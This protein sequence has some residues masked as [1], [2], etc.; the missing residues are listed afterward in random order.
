MNDSIDDP[1]AIRSAD[2][3][4]VARALDA[5]RARTLD[6]FAATRA[7]LGSKLEL[8]YAAEVNPPL[9]ELGHVGWFEEFWIG[10]NCERLR[11]QAARL[12]APRAA[13][14][15]AGA[16]ALYDSSRVAHARRWHLDLPDAARTL[17]QLAQIRERTQRL[18]RNSAPDDDALYF[19]RLVLMH[20]AMHAEAAAMIA[21][22]LAFDVRAALPAASPAAS[23]HAGELFLP[24][25]RV[26]VG[27]HE[28]GFAF[29]NELGAHAIELPPFTI[30][31]APVTWGAYLPFIEAGGYDNAKAWTRDG[32]ACR[33]TCRAAKA[34]HCAARASDA[35]TISI[36]ASRPFI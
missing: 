9:W 4:L 6:V 15:L 27:A 19:F 10:R 22:T 25:A 24:A 21:Q 36:R 14:L 3:G 26:V 8:R 31:R 7:A 16:D 20:E 32:W 13:P 23:A 34:A 5:A 2:T 1:Y 30:G 29:D 18:L 35:G 33:A 28:G 12:E 17:A 11:G